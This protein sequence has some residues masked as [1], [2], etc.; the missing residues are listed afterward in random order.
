MARDLAA[1][2][3][4]VAAT[5]NTVCFTETPLE[6][7]WTMCVDIE[8]RSIRF[9]GYG[10]AFTKTFARLQGVN[11]VWYLDITP[12]PPLADQPRR[13]ARRRSGQSGNPRRRDRSPSSST[14]HGPDP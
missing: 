14:G 2:F 1:K 8:G 7:A 9:N 3:P 10:L 11:P 12:R 13:A 5:Q 6:H 4:E